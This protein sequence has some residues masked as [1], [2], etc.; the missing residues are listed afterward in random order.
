MI[1]ETELNELVLC[2]T[3]EYADDFFEFISDLHK[4]MDNR[5]AK[6]DDRSNVL[7]S[8][9]VIFNLCSEVIARDLSPFST[10]TVNTTLEGFITRIFQRMPEYR[11]LFE[12]FSKEVDVNEN[13]S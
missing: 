2:L 10:E 12:I 13:N 9:N 4:E 1:S 5:I 3:K 8:F 6:L 11:N 7:V